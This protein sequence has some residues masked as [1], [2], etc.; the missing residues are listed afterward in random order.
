MPDSRSSPAATIPGGGVAAPVSAPHRRRSRLRGDKAIAVAVLIPSIVAV[1]IFIYAFIVYTFFVSVVK[2]PT[3]LPDYTFVG[4]DNWIRMFNDERFQIDIRNLVLFG[5]GFMTQCIVLGFLL[6]SLLDQKIKSEAV[7]RTIFI[8]PFAV[9]GIVTGVVWRWLMYPSA[10]LNQLFEIFGLGFLKSKWNTDP[11]WGVL[12]I[13]IAAAWQFSGY[14]MALYLAGLRGISY[15]LREAAAID[16]ANTW[17]LYRRII[18]PLL[19]PVTFTA[20]V[21]T[22]MGAIRVFDIP[23]V[24]GS[25]AAFSTD[26]LSS[27]MFQLV[28][29][30]NRIALG[31][32]IAGVMIILAAFLVGPYLAS[33]QLEE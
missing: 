30:A 18:I 2:W 13:S 6:A 9:S 19:A 31:A 24:L 23:Q 10:G 7:F 17:Q 14:V 28:F 22:G 16:G 15:E 33:M 26:F 8:F 12:A 3:L 11:T 25:G 32:V 4:L 21:L 20:I 5:A 29:G 1:A 27:Y